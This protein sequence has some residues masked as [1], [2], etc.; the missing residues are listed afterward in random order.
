MTKTVLVTGATGF[1]GSHVARQLADRG[2]DVRVL[3]RRT[4]VLDRLAGLPVALHHGDVTDRDSVFAAAEGVDAVIHCAAL[5]DLGARDT[6]PMFEVNVVGARNVLEAAAANEAVG[7]HVSSVSALGD[8]GDGVADE[9]WWNERQANVGYYRIKREAHLQARELAA[10]GAKV[11]I[12]SP[13]GIYGIG[14]DSEMA[15]LIKMFVNYPTPFGYVPTLYQ[16]LVQV[17]DCADGLIRIA[18]DG[19]DGREYILCT[20]VVTV[21]QWFE[22]IAAAAGRRPPTYWLSAEAIQKILA[23]ATKIME[24]VGINSTQAVEIADILSGNQ[25]FSGDR[26]RN[27]LGWAPRPLQQGM[28][29]IADALWN[30]K[31]DARRAKAA[32]RRSRGR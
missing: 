13:G 1:L 30:E 16:S 22:A 15:Q 5:V 2:D 29:E 12:G 10:Q 4:S 14:D 17:D 9:D 27:E 7:V 3:V 19:I 8:S 18:D 31:L 23:P 26:M 11:R 6:G 20:D 25:A 28:D 24:R 21:R 32:A